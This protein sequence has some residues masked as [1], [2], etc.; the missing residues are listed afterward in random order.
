MGAGSLTLQNAYQRTEKF[1]SQII[2]VLLRVALPEPD[3]KDKNLRTLG[4]ALNPLELDDRYFAFRTIVEGNVDY[5]QKIAATL[6]VRLKREVDVAVKDEN[7]WYR[8]PFREGEVTV[9]DKPMRKGEMLD[10]LEESAGLRQHGAVIVP[11]FANLSMR[12]ARYLQRKAPEGSTM[13]A[14]VEPSTLHRLKER[15]SGSKPRTRKIALSS[16]E[17]DA[18]TSEFV[19]VY[20]PATA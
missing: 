10:A 15:F 18:L 16:A 17:A 2:D 3:P 20:A 4:W 8:V 1:P 9:Y 6:D 7:G 13:V 12:T 11:I 19:R 14:V 5:A